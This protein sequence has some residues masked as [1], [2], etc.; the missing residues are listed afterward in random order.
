MYFFDK[1]IWITNVLSDDEEEDQEPEEG[2]VGAEEEHDDI[3]D[4]TCIEDDKYN[5]ELFPEEDKPEQKP[6]SEVEEK[7]DCP[8][9]S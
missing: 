2:G 5:E 4:K 8:Y 1:D 9:F 7:Y 6:A 3:E